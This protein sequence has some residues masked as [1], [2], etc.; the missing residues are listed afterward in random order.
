MEYPFRLFVSRH[1]IEH[2]GI[3]FDSFQIPTSDKR[4][5]VLRPLFS[6]EIYIR[7]SFFVSLFFRYLVRMFSESYIC[8]LIYIFSLFVFRSI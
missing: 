8:A 2:S 7:K 1:I 5:M 6:H 4:G 3:Y